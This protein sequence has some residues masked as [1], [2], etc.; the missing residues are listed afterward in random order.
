MALS[1]QSMA[2]NARAASFALAAAS[3]EKRNQALDAIASLIE[4][5]K[6][7]IMAANALDVE[8][9]IAA[10]V[11]APL[12]SRLRVTE[13]K[14]Q[15]MA[16]GLRALGGFAGSAGARGLC[17]GAFTGAQALPRSMP[18]RCNRRNF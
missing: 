15:R 14:C 17:Q 2:Q 11:S 10:E 3:L 18:Y 9:A 4:T 6:A 8:D 7:E 16:D 13:Q 12:I 1:I 5:K